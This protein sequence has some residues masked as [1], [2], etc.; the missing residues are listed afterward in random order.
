[1]LLAGPDSRTDIMYID[2]VEFS[3]LTGFVYNWFCSVVSS[4]C[5]ILECYNFFWSR[6]EYKIK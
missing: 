4:H 6:V 3:I 1:M 2:F 5:S